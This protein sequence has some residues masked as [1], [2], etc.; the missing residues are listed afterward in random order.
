MY[1]V[2]L[3][4]LVLLQ[5]AKIPMKLELQLKPDFPK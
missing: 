4:P 2:V 3:N 5:P 1:I